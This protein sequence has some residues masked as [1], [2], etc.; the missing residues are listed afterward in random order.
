MSAMGDTFY[1][2][3]AGRTH[4]HGQDLSPYTPVGFPNEPI[5]SLPSRGVATQPHRLLTYLYQVSSF[6]LPI[7]YDSSLITPVS[8]TQSEPILTT[9][10]IST[11]KDSAIKLSPTQMSPT[12][13][14][15]GS[16][17]E[18]G[19]GN[20]TSEMKHRDPPG[21]RRISAADNS[22]PA[23]PVVCYAPYFG[24]FGVSATPVSAS[25]S[26]AGLVPSP[27]MNA[28]NGRGSGDIPTGRNSS[29]RIN[30]SYLGHNQAPVLLST[31]NPLSL[32]AVSKDDG[33]DY[34]HGSL[35][36]V[37]PSSTTHSSFAES[38]GPLPSRR[39]R[40][41]LRDSQDGEVVLS[42]EMTPEEQILMQLTAQENLPWKEVAAR[43]KEQ[44]GKAMK[45]PALQMRKKRLVERLRVWTP[46]EVE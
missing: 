1:S 17:E 12:Y 38:V 15:L 22:F 19:D 36:P 28:T 46:N 26:S 4:L 6:N 16:D 10:T 5:C 27:R 44:T 9:S 43:F 34:R 14:W 18:Y 7:Q 13:P 25:T 30:Q 24:Q 2:I 33:Q 41:P 31:P 29:P 45:V 35:Q 23:S 37:S 42:G 20:K 3:Q 11:Q 40:K 21:T 8:L 39:K 32:R